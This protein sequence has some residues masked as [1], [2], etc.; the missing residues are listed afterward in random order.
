MKLNSARN[1]LIATWEQARVPLAVQR[2]GSCLGPVQQ[3]A[4]DPAPAPARMYRAAVPHLVQHPGRGPGDESA[5]PH[6]GPAVEDAHRAALEI[7]VRIVPVLEQDLF[8]EVLP[9]VVRR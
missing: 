5:V 4:A 9:A 8:G 2:D 7:A 3:M 6:Q 1:T